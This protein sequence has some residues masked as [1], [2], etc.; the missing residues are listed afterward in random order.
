MGHVGRL[1]GAEQRL[2]TNTRQGRQEAGRAARCGKRAK[3]EGQDRK[4]Q[5]PI[6]SLGRY[7]LIG[8]RHIRST[9]AVLRLPDL[10]ERCEATL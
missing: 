3:R 9:K 8:G 2:S 4:A 6:V 5:M 7:C 10:L 1:I